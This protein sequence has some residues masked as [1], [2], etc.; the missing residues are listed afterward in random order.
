M[1]RPKH[2]ERRAMQD[3]MFTAIAS[4]NN[5]DFTVYRLGYTIHIALGGIGE[6][7]VLREAK[8]ALLPSSHLFVEWLNLLQHGRVTRHLTQNIAFITIPSAQRQAW[9]GIEDI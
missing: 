5:R 6:S 9:Q 1:S 8:G 4:R 7:V 3:D 2:L